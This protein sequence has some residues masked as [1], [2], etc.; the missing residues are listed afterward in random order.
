M[1]HTKSGR[2][3]QVRPGARR[4]W[5]VTMKLMP[6]TMLAEPTMKMPSS[7][8]T[9]A[10][11][12]RGA[13]RGVERPAGVGAA[14][15]HGDEDDGGAG[16]VEIEAEQVEAGEGDVARADHQRHHEV[17]EGAGDGGDEEE[18]DH[19]DPVE[20]E[21]AVVSGG[22]DQGALGREQLQPDDHGEDAAEEERAEDGD[23]EHHADA[24][25]IAGVEPGSRRGAGGEV[26]PPLGLGGRRGL[27]EERFANFRRSAHKRALRPARARRSC[28]A[29]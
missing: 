4:V 2:R 8:G 10:V 16:E 23:E 6:E 19:H 25:V 5:M 12:G 11:R 21:E 17:A 24:L 7:T 27:G 22:A 26:A 18:E 1:D 3:I 13:V 20:R 9:T 28:A 14:F 15:E 29:I